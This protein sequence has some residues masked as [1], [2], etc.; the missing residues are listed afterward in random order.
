MKCITSH[1]I[2]FTQ[3]NNGNNDSID[4]TMNTM[5]IGVVR[6]FTT[7]SIPMILLN[8]KGNMFSAA[9]DAT[10]YLNLYQY[11]Q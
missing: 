9:T 11:D 1:I 3:S 6:H 4:G 8:A 5:R 10:P 2:V 7:L